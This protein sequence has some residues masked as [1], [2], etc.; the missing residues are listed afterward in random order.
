MS[1]RLAGGGVKG[2]AGKEGE[3][4]ERKRK[5]VRDFSVTWVV[6]VALYIQFLFLEVHQLSHKNKCWS[7]IRTMFVN[8]ARSFIL[9]SVA[10]LF[11]NPRL[12]ALPFHW[13]ALLVPDGLCSNTD[14]FQVSL[15]AYCTLGSDCLVATSEC[16]VGRPI[17]AQSQPCME[18]PQTYFLHWALLAPRLTL[19]SQTTPFF[20]LCSHL[21]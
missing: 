2:E 8:K 3:R 4:R 10:G 17:S 9:K 18:A 15:F 21:Y 7:L 12:S 5:A 16:E 6:N 1:E 20:S 14:L 19:L 13:W 11:F